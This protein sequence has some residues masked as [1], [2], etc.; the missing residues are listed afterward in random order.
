MTTD[1]DWASAAVHE[2][3]RRI[4]A[5]RERRKMTVQQLSD[6]CAELGLP[7]GRVTLAKLENGLRQ[8]VTPYEIVVIAA[9]LGAAPIELIFPIGLE[10]RIE[11]WPGA[12]VDP[13]EAVSW[14]SG[15]TVV[16]TT[17]GSVDI[18][19]PRHGQESN[20]Y[21][22]H[23]HRSL[24]SQLTAKE[25]EA[26]RVAADA[27]ADPENATLR[28]AVTR[29]RNDAD[30]WRKFLIPQLSRIR[31]DM[32]ERGMILPPLPSGLDLDDRA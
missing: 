4:A 18:H 16:D 2:S 6:R 7:I 25:G 8:S 17:A 23:E 14:F 27:E 9:A 24:V 12:E 15:D 5:Y 32:S 11:L 3:G 30:D 21:L 19:G 28:A 22:L 31:D 20:T 1:P 10:K 13:L 26:Q 29:A